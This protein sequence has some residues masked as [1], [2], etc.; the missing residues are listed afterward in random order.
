MINVFAAFLC[1]LRPV[2]SWKILV[3]KLTGA[4]EFKNFFDARPDLQKCITNLGEPIPEA[5]RQDPFANDYGSRDCATLS[6][7]KCLTQQRR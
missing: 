6:I 2:S 5:Y 1:E 7:E 4:D 3:D